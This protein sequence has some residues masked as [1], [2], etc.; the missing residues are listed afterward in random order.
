MRMAFLAGVMLMGVIANAQQV[1]AIKVDLL[2]K[3]IEQAKKPLVVNFWA[4]WCMPCLEEMPY[5]QEA[6]EKYLN[7]EFIFVSLDQKKAFP[8]KIDSVLTGRGWKGR[9]YWLDE[10]NA[11]Y[12]C[13]MIEKNWDGNIPSTLFINGKYRRFVGEEL[14][15]EK[16]QAELDRLF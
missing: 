1:K 2:K 15:R 8:A 6:Q 9:F 16:L 14:S 3:E 4:S 10:T 5:F 13:P 7:A 11:D 12:F